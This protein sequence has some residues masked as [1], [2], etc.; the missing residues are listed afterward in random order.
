MP[1]TVTCQSD[2]P[3]A[4]TA[5]YATDLPG[6]IPVPDVEDKGTGASS[7]SKTRGKRKHEGD[8]GDEAR[9]DDPANPEDNQEM[10]SVEVYGLGKRKAGD[11]KRKGQI[12]Q[13]KYDLC[14]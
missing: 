11:G 12:H 8:E 1:S 10:G 5:S 9:G 4:S 14:E 7:S 6:Y 2:V 13:G 3:A